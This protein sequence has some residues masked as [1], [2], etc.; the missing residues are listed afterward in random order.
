MAPQQSIFMISNVADIEKLVLKTASDNGYDYLT[1]FDI[2]AI[3]RNKAL[4]DLSMMGISAASLFPGIDG[5]CE[6]MKFRNFP[7]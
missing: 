7:E 3:E 4:A 5:I 1:A 2:P 6:H